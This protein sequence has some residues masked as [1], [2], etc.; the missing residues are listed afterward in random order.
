MSGE[1]HHV[2]IY[3]SDLSRTCRFWGWLLERLGYETFQSWELGKSWKLG[4]TY[5]VFVQ[6][7]KKYKSSSYNRCNVGLN[8]LA[9][10]VDSKYEME[11]IRQELQKMGTKM[12][13]GDRFPYAGGK[14]HCAL[15]FEDP[16]G[17]KVEL[18]VSEKDGG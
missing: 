12:L 10:Y 6:V 13:Y 14:E 4:A 15:Y 16:D 11:C 2:E 5:L 18:V 7:Q 17:I 3:V 9:F 1:L 8:H